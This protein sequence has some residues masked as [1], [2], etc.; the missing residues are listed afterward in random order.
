[1]AVSWLVVVHDI[2]GGW[3]KCTGRPFKADSPLHVDADAEL[4]LSVAVQGFRTAAGQCPQ[5][6][7]PGRRRQH[8]E[9]YVSLSGEALKLANRFALR[10]GL[11]A[12]VPIVQNHGF[13]MAAAPMPM[14]VKRTSRRTGW[15]R[16]ISLRRLPEG[17]LACY[18]LGP[19]E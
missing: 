12:F 4:A 14:C 11:G 9:V 10:E 7:E 13:N 3:P 19:S 8:F 15:L 18:G 1:M 2:D 5:I 16:G 17:M 6:V